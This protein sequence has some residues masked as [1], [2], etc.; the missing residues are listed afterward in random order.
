LFGVALVVSAQPAAKKTDIYATAVIEAAKRT[1]EKFLAV[2]KGE[3]VAAD[4]PDHVDEIR[5]EVLT[6]DQVIA[7]SKDAK[8]AVYVLKVHPAETAGAL[9]KVRVMQ[10]TV[11]W[12]TQRVA[13]WRHEGIRGNWSTVEYGLR[14]WF[15]VFFALDRATRKYQVVKVE[16]GSL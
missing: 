2:D 14:G 4:Y 16:T 5:V 13:L 12:S 11:A 6:R 8:K 10:G 3:S 9:L 1:G 7:R 15:D